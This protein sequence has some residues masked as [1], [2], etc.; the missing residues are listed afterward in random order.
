M[1]IAMI[2]LGKMGNNMSVRLLNDKHRVVVFDLNK[3]VVK[4]L[5]GKGAVAADDLADVVKKLNGPGPKVIWLMLP[6]Q[7]PIE[8][9]LEVLVPLLAKGDVIIDGGNSKFTMAQERSKRLAEKGIGY[10]DAGT[11][12]GLWGLKFGYCLM[13]G[14][15]KESF[16]KAEPIIKTLAPP[17]GY[18]HCGAS[19]SGHFTK[20]VHNGIEYGMMQ[21]YAEGFELLSKSGF[22]LDLAKIA[23]LWGQGSVV[24]SWLLELLADALKADPKLEHVKGYVEDTGEGRWTVEQAI[25]KAVP[26]P[27]ITEALFARFRS[28][29]NEDTAFGSKINAA[30]RNQFGGHA[31]KK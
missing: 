8:K 26:M 21:A 12:G 24:R 9:S 23:D 14:G 20:M 2:G 1:D 6:G 30:L 17:N 5:A 7:G 27:V 28:R 18:H 25:E 22:D 3:D 13:V 29:Q 11:S 16:A 4:E 19:G 31:I 15:D 10:L